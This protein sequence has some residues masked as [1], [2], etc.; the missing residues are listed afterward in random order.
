MRKDELTRRQFLRFCTAFAAGS[1]LAACKTG[2]TDEARPTGGIST[3]VP[4]IITTAPPPS[5]THSARIEVLT[6]GLNFPE[7]PAFD[8]QGILWC[9]ELQ[10]GNLVRWQ[11]GKVQRY[12]TQGGPNGMAFDHKNRAWVTDSQQNA[13]RRFDPATGKWE[14]IADKLDGHL[15]GAPNDLAFDP[16]GNLV[17]TC[18]VV[19]SEEAVGYVCCLQPDGTLVKIAEGLHFPNGLEFIDNG[20]ILVVAESRRGRLS[21]G[22]WD[23][24]AAKWTDPR[25]WAEVGIDGPDGM[26]AGADGLL[27]VAMYGYGQIKAVDAQGKTARVY[28]LP[29]KNP[30]NVTVDPSGKL[31]LVVTETEHGQLLSLPD[32]KPGTAIFDGG[33]A[34]Q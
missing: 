2:R 34:W 32:I 18:P 19:W 30:T 5:P 26:V 28:E 8:A 12:P 3:G 4:T 16:L 33:D 23:P 21:T 15:L 22:R 31:G 24:A 6:S 29:G 27:Y 14:T 1:L 20:Q 10:G 17:F 13:I 7:G 11:D 9:T 25:P